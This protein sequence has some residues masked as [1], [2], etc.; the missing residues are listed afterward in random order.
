METKTLETTMGTMFTTTILTR[1]LQLQLQQLL[2]P[3]PQRPQLQLQ[4]LLQEQQLPQQE[5][6][7]QLQSQQ[8]SQQQQYMHQLLYQQ[9]LGETIT[10]AATVE[11]K[12]LETTMGKTTTTIN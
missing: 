6:Q 8:H 5:S 3:Q 11:M 4:L 10:L 9:V 2:Q 12:T 7:L 1:N